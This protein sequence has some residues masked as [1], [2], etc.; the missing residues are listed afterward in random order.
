[1]HL[2]FFIQYRTPEKHKIKELALK[3]IA[4]PLF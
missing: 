2:I 1:M 3:G 4:I